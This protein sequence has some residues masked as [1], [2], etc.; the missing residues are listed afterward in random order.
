MGLPVSVATDH[1]PFFHQQS[2][3]FHEREEYAWHPARLR[4]VSS[5]APTADPGERWCPGPRAGELAVE[6]AC[7]L[8]ARLEDCGEPIVIDVAPGATAL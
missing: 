2:L 8:D 1:Y 3:V 4:V 7:D 5:G 6:A